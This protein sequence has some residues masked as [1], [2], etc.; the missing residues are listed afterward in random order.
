MVAYSSH[1]NNATKSRYNLYE[2]ECLAMVRAVA[3]FKCY[4]FGT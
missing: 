2:G 1:L 4:L 3:H